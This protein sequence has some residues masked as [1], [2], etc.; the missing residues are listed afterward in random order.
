MG[1]ERWLEA[2]KLLNRSLAVVQRDWRLSWN[3]GWCYFKV[4]RL[5]DARKHLI[6]AAKL[7]PENPTC[8]WALGNVYLQRKQ[9]RKAEILLSESLKIKESHLTRIALALAYLSQGKVTEAEKMHPENIRR[10]P[11]KGTRYESYAAFLSDVGRETEAQRMNR[12][13]AK[14]KRVN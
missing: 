4:D 1:K 8:K 12:K 10:K 6:Q 11:E 9:F 7:A 5:D 13:A 14:I 3:L 2:V